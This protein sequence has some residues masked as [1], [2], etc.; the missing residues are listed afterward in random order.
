MYERYSSAYAATDFVSIER[1]VSVP[2]KHGW[3]AL[4][5]FGESEESFNFM[6]LKKQLIC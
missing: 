2:N 4:R 6:H 5:A 1:I 3:D